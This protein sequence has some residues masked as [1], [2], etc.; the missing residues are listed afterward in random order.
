LAVDIFRIPAAGMKLPLP[1]LVL[2]L[3]FCVSLLRALLGISSL[4]PKVPGKAV[5]LCMTCAVFWLYHLGSAMRAVDLSVALVNHLKL[6][7]GMLCFVIIIFST[8]FLAPRFDKMWSVHFIVASLL[9]LALMYRYAIV[10]G[11]PFLGID[12]DSPTRFGKN[13]LGWFLAATMPYMLSFY[14]SRSGGHRMLIPLQIHVLAWLYTASRGSW[15]CGFVGCLIALFVLRRQ[16]RFPVFVKRLAL[17]AIPL[18]LLGSLAIAV[19]DLPI[20]M[21]SLDMMARLTTSSGQGSNSVSDRVRT[22]MMDRH[23]EIFEEQPIVGQGLTNSLSGHEILSHNDYLYLMT[24]LGAVGLLLFIAFLFAIISVAW[25]RA[26]EHWCSAAAL[27]SVVSIVCY[28]SLINVYTSP[29][30]WIL[31]GLAAVPALAGDQLT[32]TRGA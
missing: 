14:L 24:D 5:F 2:L 28:L 19:F 31:L 11:M 13:Q 21:Q 22:E 4:V 23:L 26:P 3:V 32:V 1:V 12:W 16:I 8:S 20:N 18:V 30:F 17:L 27:G 6:T 15:L 25:S 10:F 7:V 29:M 9:L